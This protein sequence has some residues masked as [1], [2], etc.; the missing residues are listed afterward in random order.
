MAAR[1]RSE[2]IEVEQNEK[3]AEKRKQVTK[4]RIE[5]QSKIIPFK[6]ALHH[7]YSNCSDVD[8]I[9]QAYYDTL[10]ENSANK[11][12]V[13]SYS[14]GMKKSASVITASG[15]GGKSDS[16]VLRTVTHKPRRPVQIAVDK[17]AVSSLLT[18]LRPFKINTRV[19]EELRSPGL[20]VSFSEQDDDFF[21]GKGR[22]KSKTMAGTR[23]TNVLAPTQALKEI[24]EY[25]TIKPSFTG[26]R[27]REKSS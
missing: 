20:P 21:S 2:L 10:L 25:E 23:P 16:Y 26:G 11:M 22:L 24:A 9:D 5:L 18:P 17:V 1:D 7:D 14:S 12:A 8:M 15:A 13:L 3:V 4:M 6:K 19:K 27:H